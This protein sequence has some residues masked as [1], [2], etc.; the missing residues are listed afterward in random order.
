[1]R[2]VASIFAALIV[3]LASPKEASAED[4]WFGADKVLHFGVSAALS[5]GGYALASLAFDR[6]WE[7]ATTGAVFSLTLGAAKEFY[8]LA[9]HGDASWKDFTW[10]VAGTAL[11]TGI[12]L[13][14]DAAVSG[15]NRVEPANRPVGLA[16]QF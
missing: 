8:D 15:G 2:T 13:L 11:G 12:A 7:R 16:V 9:G 6:K 4:E 5:G 14:I 1:M 10:D 3:L